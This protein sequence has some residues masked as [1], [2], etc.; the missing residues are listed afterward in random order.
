VFVTGFEAPD[1]DGEHPPDQ[2]V[3]VVSARSSP[4]KITPVRD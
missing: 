2:N 4:G 3:V 1:D